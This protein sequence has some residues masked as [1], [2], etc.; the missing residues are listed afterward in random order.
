VMGVQARHDPSAS[1]LRSS[2]SYETEDPDPD[3]I[4]TV[5]QTGCRRGDVI[6]G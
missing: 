6:S 4:Q 2:S 5:S 3:P 1:E